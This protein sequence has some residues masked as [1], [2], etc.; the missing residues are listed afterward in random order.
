MM[1]TYILKG[2]V[3][4]IIGLMALPGWAQPDGTTF[5][6]GGYFGSHSFRN[7]KRAD[8]NS[9]AA[10]VVF[11]NHRINPI[12]IEAQLAWYDEVSVM[13][14]ESDLLFTWPFLF[15][16][17][18]SEG[19]PIN[20]NIFFQARDGWGDIQY[21]RYDFS[22]GSTFRAGGQLGLAGYGGTGPDD[23]SGS[24]LD[25][26]AGL[27]TRL[28]LE[29]VGGEIDLHPGFRA[30]RFWVAESDK[31][32]RPGYELG[33]FVRGFFMD[34][35]YADF[36]FRFRWYNLTDDYPVRATSTSFLFGVGIAL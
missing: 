24:G 31:F 34:N 12:S 15:V 19:N 7:M 36:S 30:N 35:I 6:I 23:A 18:F 27:N 9:G 22:F 11:Q 1:K 10:P 32:G 28:F 29:D 14:L 13:E 5:L 33:P 21:L 8:G 4:L 3:A 16:N 25:L 2:A 20:E 26:F 17:L